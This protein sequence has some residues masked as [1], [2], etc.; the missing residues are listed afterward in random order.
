[1]ALTA[2][3]TP[4]KRFQQGE[5]VS[6]GKLNQLGLPTIS[7]AGTVGANEVGVDSYFYAGL[8]TGLPGAAV[9]TPPGSDIAACTDGMVIVFKVMNKNAGPATLQLVSVNGPLP[10]APVYRAPFTPL[11]AGDWQPGQMVEVRYRLDGDLVQNQF[12]DGGGSLTLLVIP[13]LAYTWNKTASDTSLAYVSADGTAVALLA[14]G[15]FT[16]ATSSVL[17]NGTASQPSGST[18]VAATGYWQ[19]MSLPPD[20]AVTL[21]RALRFR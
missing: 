6:N 12:Y 8:D 13:G 7:L 10:A 20:P 16:P 4:G 15:A 2:T 1:M 9:V 3:I 14:S 19:M 21:L 5:V 11:A 18:L 17:L